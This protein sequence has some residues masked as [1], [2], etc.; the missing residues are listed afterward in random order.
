[1]LIEQSQRENAK[2]RDVAARFVAS[3]SAVRP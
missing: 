3:A 1:V 2:L